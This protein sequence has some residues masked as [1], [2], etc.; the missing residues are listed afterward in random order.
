MHASTNTA[1]KQQTMWCRVARCGQ[2]NY[3]HSNS[4][5]SNIYIVDEILLFDFQIAHL[6]HSLAAAASKCQYITSQISWN[7]GAHDA[8]VWHMVFIFSHPAACRSRRWRRLLHTPV[9]VI[10]RCPHPA[11]RIIALNRSRVDD[12]C[13]STSQWLLTLTMHFQGCA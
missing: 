2:K 3:I 6:A 9:P 10:Q 5:I 11:M 8:V 7:L 12:R 4:L 13:R 1:Y